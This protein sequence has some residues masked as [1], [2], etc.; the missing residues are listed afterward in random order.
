[1]KS[2]GWGTRY[3][4]LLPD[5]HKADT[6]SFVA[7]QVLGYNKISTNR[8]RIIRSLVYIHRVVLRRF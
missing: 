5:G 1:M 6:V 7:I 8:A 3:T 4:I 2:D